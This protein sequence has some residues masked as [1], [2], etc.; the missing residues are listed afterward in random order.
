MNFGQKME[1]A[2]NNNS[3]VIG[4]YSGQ[5]RILLDAITEIIETPVKDNEHVK[6]YYL[7]MIQRA[8]QTLVKGD[9]I[10]KSQGDKTYNEILDELE[11]S[12]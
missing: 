8:E 11:D 2:R 4:M 12:N 5:I 10:F 9:K 3:Y 7:D 6:N 1:Q